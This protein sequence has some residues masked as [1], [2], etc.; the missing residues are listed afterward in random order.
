M[1]IDVEVKALSSFANIYIMFFFNYKILLIP[2][3]DALRYAGCS[4]SKTIYNNN[5]HF[6]DISSSSN[7]LEASLSASASIALQ[8]WSSFEL[9]FSS[10]FLFS[11]LITR[12][13]VIQKKVKIYRTFK[14]FFSLFN[15]ILSVL[16]F[17]LQ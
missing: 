16:F 5:T 8:L 7:S 9:Y 15:F 12:L 1:H 11:P 17:K 3:T 14:I 10:S 4:V 13:L 2:I 6:S